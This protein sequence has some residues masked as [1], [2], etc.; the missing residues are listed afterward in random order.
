MQVA[1]ATMTT[2]SAESLREFAER[3][4]LFVEGIVSLPKNAGDLSRFDAELKTAKAAGATVVR[5]T[6]IPGRRYERFRTLAEFREFEE[7][8]Q[9]MLRRAAPLAEK[10]RIM[11]AVENHKDQRL[12]ERIALF[13]QLD[14]EFVGA[15]LDTG[16]SIALLDGVY[17]PIEALAAYAFTVHLKDQALSAYDDGFLLA[18]VPLG[19]GSLDLKCIV[20]MIRKTKPDIRFCLELITRDP[21][22]VPCLTDAFWSTLP[23]VPASNL[24]KI[25]RFIRAHEADGQSIV[26]LS[27]AEQV[28]IET[29]NVLSS[30]RFA[31]EELKS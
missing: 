11:L 30:L 19:Q 5:T 28:A 9:T 15:C 21:L 7:R 25:L 4:H 27:P 2:K 29:S 31:R 1:L 10:H 20:A 6:I 16:N 3:N 24:A 8:G 13:E 26:G 12:D 14:S 23:Q 22:K 18:D 17:E